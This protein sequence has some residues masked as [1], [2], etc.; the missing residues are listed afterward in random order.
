[1]PA[2][3]TPQYK[4]AETRYRDSKT[5]EEKL[6][7]LEEMLRTIPKHKG[8][9]KMCSDIKTRI[10]KTKAQM[11][12]AKS[13][14]RKGISY[15]IPKEGSAQC[16]LIGAPNS[17]KSTL[18]HKLTTTHAAI[19]DYPYTTTRPQPGMFTYENLKFQLIDLPPISEEFF[20]P[21]MPS[22]IRVTDLILLVADLEHID[23]LDIIFNRLNSAKITLV[24]SYSDSEYH[25]RVVRIPTILLANKADKPDAAAAVQLLEE[26]YPQFHIIPTSR[27]DSSDG[28]IIG[29]EI[30][31]TLE[32][33]RGYTKPPGKQPNFDQPIVIHRGA[34]L[35]DICR[36]IHKDF[37]KDLKYARVWGSGK[38]EGQRV[39]RDYIVCEGD[40]FEFKV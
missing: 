31:N 1:M 19:G 14:G 30:F 13:S 16:A 15:H 32:L 27:V 38:F 9:E 33:V 39:Q 21:W 36:E 29:R 18:F 8:T 11:E 34:Q 28:A 26:S 22:V 3:L 35:S 12:Q 5:P 37:E 10:S 7:A 20:E 24:N 40:V 2:N 6:D 17:G 23:H 4:A 25:D